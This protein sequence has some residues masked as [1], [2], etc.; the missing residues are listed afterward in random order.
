MDDTSFVKKLVSKLLNES[1]IINMT[2]VNSNNKKYLTNNIAPHAVSS[3]TLSTGDE[4]YGH[5]R[6]LSFSDYCTID[7]AST[8]SSVSHSTS[9]STPR[10]H[11]NDAIMSDHHED[12]LTR[13][14]SK[15]RILE[16]DDEEM[17]GSADFKDLC[18]SCASHP[19]VNMILFIFCY[20]SFMVFAAC[21]FALTEKSTEVALKVNMTMEQIIFLRD[22]PS[23]EGKVT[24]TSFLLFVIDYYLYLPSPRLPPFIGNIPPF[25][26]SSCLCRFCSFCSRFL[27]SLS[28]NNSS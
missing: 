27:S 4:S 15:R 6:R 24:F 12:D 22:N 28:P 8:S 2:S 1:I 13:G 10:L 18:G 5:H 7:G 3:S 17:S 23:V 26:S 21:I 16:E 20:I 25:F 9:P 11:Q 14:G 19:R